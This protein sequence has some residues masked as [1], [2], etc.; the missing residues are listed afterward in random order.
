MNSCRWTTVAPGRHGA[1]RVRAPAPKRIVVG[2]GGDGTLN[3]VAAAVLGQGV[4]FGILPQGTFNY[5]GR[6]YGISQETEV[7]LRAA[8]RQVRPVQVGLLNDRPFL[9]NASLGL[10]PQLLEDREAFKQKFG[11]NRLVA[12]WSGLV[13]LMRAPRQLACSSSTKAAP[14]IC[15]RRRWSWA[16]TSC[17]SSTW[18]SRPTSW[19]GNA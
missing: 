2:A 19:T 11:R 18:E 9:V 17:N 14:A 3:T 10:Y 6:R 1:R 13:T 8:A 5:F 7:A 4:P 12:L 16:T 15:A